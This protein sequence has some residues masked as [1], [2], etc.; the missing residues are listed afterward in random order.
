MDDAAKID[1][2]F[3]LTL[4]A[5]VVQFALVILLVLLVAIGVMPWEPRSTIYLISGVLLGSLS[6][7]TARSIHQDRND[8]AGIERR[9]QETATRLG[10]AVI[11]LSV[12]VVA[13]LIVWG[14]AG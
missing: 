2:A 5:G 3:R 13:G 10:A 12:V 7:V 6:L 1:R 9:F 4:I 14:L 11:V 8:P